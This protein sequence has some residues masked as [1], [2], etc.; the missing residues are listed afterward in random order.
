M[1]Y[2]LSF[3]T[4]VTKLFIYFVKKIQYLFIFFKF[5]LHSMF[6]KKLSK[7]KYLYYGN[8]FLNLNFFQF[9]KKI[10]KKIPKKSKEYK[11]AQFFLGSHIFNNRKEDPQIYFNN[12]FVSKSKLKKKLFYPPKIL[13][14]KIDNSSFNLDNEIDSYIYK[15]KLNSYSDLKQK[16]I[17]RYYQSEHNLHKIK[18]FKLLANLL[19]KKINQRNTQLINLKTNYKFKI[20]K[21]WFVKSKQG[22]D[23]LAHNHPEG[24][25]SGI[26]Y[27]KV[28]KK[29]SPGLLKI[30]NP[31]DN[32]KVISQIKNY[33]KKDKEIIIKPAENSLIIFNSYLLHSVINQ[34]SNESRISIPFDA[35]I[36]K[37]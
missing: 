3:F 18:K 7:K 5:C 27:Y 19:E 33:V 24:V 25:I 11:Y 32:I 31:R 2:I 34:S 14:V 23:L 17:Y 15:R 26:Y 35:N 4:S 6:S 16:E 30:K 37:N 29:K 21:M 8:F 10:L 28:P 1:F 20:N 9:S 12:F 13:I 22:I 36:S